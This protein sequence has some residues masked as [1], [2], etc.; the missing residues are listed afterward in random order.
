MIIKNITIQNFRSYYGK[1]SFDI[2]E[3]LTL[4]IGS[5]G[6]GKTTFYEALE[7][8]FDTA[9]SRSLIDEK[10]ISRK[11]CK[12]LVAGE[13]DKVEVSMTFDHYGENKLVKKF[14]F[15]RALDNS[16]EL[17]DYEFT[18]W[19]QDGVERR[20]VSGDQID[21]YFDAL[22]R[23]YCLFKG[24]SELNIFNKPDTL[25]SLVDTFSDVREF[26]PY[27][28][29]AEFARDC[30]EEATRN[31]LKADRK[32]EKET[33][34]LDDQ[35]TSLRR[36]IDSALR[37]FNTQTNEALNFA[38]LLSDLE[39]S[40]EASSI[41]NDINQRITR[42]KAKRDDYAF[43]IKEDYTIRLL[44]DKWILMGLAPI[45][46]EFTEKISVAQR[47][48]RRE[49][50]AHAEEIGARKS[51]A[52]IH[53]QLKDGIVPLAPFIPGEDTMRE[54]LADH[55]CKVCGT[56]APEGSPQYEFMLRRLN[57]YLATLNP[58]E[59]EEEE[60]PLFPYAYIDEL[61][62]RSVVL[63]TKSTF[64]HNIKREIRDDVEFNQ[65]LKEN[66]RRCEDNIA[67]LEEDKT[68]ILA[69]ADGLDEEDLINAFR[70]IGEWNAAKS[71][72]E[73][74]AA[75]LE[76]KLEYL[77]TQLKEAEHR[78]D[79]IASKSSAAGMYSRVSAALRKIADAFASAKIRNKRDF[80]DRLER[81]ANHY[82]GVL[83]VDDFKGVIELKERADKQVAIM[84]MDSNRDI[85]HNPNTAL[86]TTMYMSILFAIADLT[87]LKRD[88]N[89]PLIFD[90]PTSSF[91]D[92]KESDFFKVIG[93][94]NKQTIIVT[95]SFLTTGIDGT[96][97][98]DKSM[99]DQIHGRVYQIAKKR[100]FDDK[101][102]STIETVTTLIKSN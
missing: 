75:K 72:A 4:I 1:T 26:D 41:I 21:F 22:V 78:Y 52:K 64:L 35:I 12:E 101:D 46:R 25:N 79:E 71:D 69:Q 62:R 20:H 68:R 98:L 74:S 97:V 14:E 82:L 81:R 91:T 76:A 29:F 38:K 61:H 28:S 58:K 8:L 18:L 51:E 19:Q 5:N 60:V 56:E 49:E 7:W 48:K 92:V 63:Q 47:A 6:D 17:S 65:R 15:K 2:G 94:I 90:A 45:A 102:L 10:Y 53:Q 32:N 33:R 95:K 77:R 83:N 70:N 86:Q 11:R 66:V 57:E 54:M 89:Y 100:P 59:E 88:N 30:S 37:E 3:G 99:L 67:K 13:V 50:L 9:N 16:I 96:S 93:D 34:E 73:K 84:L 42:E 27:V 85:I 43:K 36:D 44:D 55:V 40:H 24:E 39:R 80:I 31:A 23:Q 87:T